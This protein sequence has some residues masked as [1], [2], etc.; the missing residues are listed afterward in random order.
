[1]RMQGL[2]S[3]ARQL[4]DLGFPADAV[5]LYSESLA[6][7][8]SIPEGSPNYIGNREGIIASARKG[9]D[10]ALQGLKDEQLV[11]TVRGLLEPPA[12]VKEAGKRSPRRSR[13]IGTRR[14][15]SSC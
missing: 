9:L 8:E 6:T 1:M 3:V 2:A 5:P 4:V 15:T 13:R 7:A 12:E 14:S 11:T 10:Q